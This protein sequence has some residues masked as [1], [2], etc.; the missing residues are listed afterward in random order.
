MPQL[1][2]LLICFLQ[3]F[4][5][6]HLFTLVAHLFVPAVAVSWG[7]LLTVFLAACYLSLL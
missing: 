7:N 3:F 4:L 5:I 1:L 2:F 6:Q